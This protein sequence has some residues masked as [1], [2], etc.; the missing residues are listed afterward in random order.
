MNDSIRHQGLRKRLV[1]GLKIKGIKDQHVLDAIGKVPRHLFMESSFINFA[2]KDQAFPIAA[3]QTISQPYTV[4][5]QTELLAIEKF[6]KVLEVGTGSG[7]Q[8]AVLIEMGASVFTIERQKELYLMV[9][10]FL[11]KIGYNPKFFYGD[12]YKGLPTYGPFD[13]ILVTA[14]APSVPEELKSQLKIGGKMVIPVGYSDKQTMHLIIRRSEDEFDTE[15][16][17]SFIFVPLL[18]GTVN[19]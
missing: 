2:Y 11:P 18:K 4:A 13:K 7:Y 8:A 15:K 1:E 14:A 16:H 3:G 9:I 19:S 10:D 5:F 12:G 6:D 17:G